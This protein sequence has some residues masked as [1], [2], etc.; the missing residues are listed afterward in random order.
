MNT[1]HLTAFSTSNLYFF[2]LSCQYC[3]H[4]VWRC[5][6]SESGMCHLSWKVNFSPLLAAL[7][8][9]HTS[10]SLKRK[11]WRSFLTPSTNQNIYFSLNFRKEHISFQRHIHER[12]CSIFNGCVHM[13]HYFL[14]KK[15][16][17]STDEPT[18]GRFDQQNKVAIK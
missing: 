1:Y 17:Y 14:K 4:S 10:T 9:A 18:R 7:Y 13:I 5:P 6:T 8:L 12:K 16:L 11:R 15:R 2:V 3:F